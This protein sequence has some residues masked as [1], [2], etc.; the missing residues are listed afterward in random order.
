MKILKRVLIGIA[1]IAA[2]LVSV[3]YLCPGLVVNS[4]MSFA[5]FSAGLER[6][7][8]KA[9]NYNW[10]YLEG[11][12]GDTVLFIHGLG[13]GKDTWGSMLSAFTG[14]YRV[15]APD[16]PGTNESG[17]I[18]DKIFTITD[19]GDEI[20]NFV[21]ALGLDRFHIIGLSSGGAMAAYY[22]SKYPAKV[23]SASLIGPF[24]IQ[25]KV[26][27]DFRKAYE[28]GENPIV[29]RT[30]EGFDMKMSYVAY[31]PVSAPRHI[32]AYLADLYAPTYDFYIT[33][34][35]NEIDVEGWDMLRRYLPG[36]KCPT[37]AIF[38]DRDRITDV[39]CI[40]VFK[41]DVKNITP[42]VMKD[43][44]HVTYLDKPEETAAVV[45]DFI[46]AHSGN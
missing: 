31:K 46:T 37:L 44:G 18:G 38:G 32:K 35:R 16:L 11:G 22:V 19:A 17:S 2:V 33:T 23:K 21:T 6:R 30:P 1:A 7:E 8:I 27:T 45:K 9:G 42:Y 14:S 12:K 3:F 43:A 10:V 4:G 13:G 41:R 34:F 5:R 26:I 20:E 28:R 24:G 39:S 40:E 25:T 15:I 36:I 29:F